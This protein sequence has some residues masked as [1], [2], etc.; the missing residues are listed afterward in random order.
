VRYQREKQL[1]AVPWVGVLDSNHH[2]IALNFRIFE[3]STQ[4]ARVQPEEAK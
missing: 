3:I 4:R 2:E 1:L